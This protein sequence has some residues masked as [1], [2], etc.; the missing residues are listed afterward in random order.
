MMPPTPPDDTTSAATEPRPQPPGG[1]L[2]VLGSMAGSVVGSVVGG[3]RSVVQ[4]GLGARA[5]GYALE[6][7][8]YVVEAPAS[9]VL[10]LGA[11]VEDAALGVGAAVCYGIEAQG[12]I[13]G[14]YILGDRAS[15][16]VVPRA[17][18]VPT[19]LDDR[20]PQRRYV[21]GQR[22]H[23]R[24]RLRSSSPT[25][26]AQSIPSR[27]ERGRVR[28]WARAKCYAPLDREAAVIAGEVVTR[29]KLL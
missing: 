17:S 28:E 12:R 14:S 18:K 22:S 4:T 29:K 15:D 20:W 24:G 27:L 21:A 3:V 1:Y 23:L 6:S 19:H 16:D 25:V 2:G 5:P 7:V 26:R 8:R 10:E 13:V 9:H 11:A